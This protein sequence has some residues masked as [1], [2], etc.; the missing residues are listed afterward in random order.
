MY[1]SWRAQWRDWVAI[2]RDDLNRLLFPSDQS[3]P[4]PPFNPPQITRFIIMSFDSSV[5][6]LID[7]NRVSYGYSNQLL[8][9]GTLS[10]KVPPSSVM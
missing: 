10:V 2:S 4:F 6:I 8:P 3:T 9:I 5:V 7:G 1:S